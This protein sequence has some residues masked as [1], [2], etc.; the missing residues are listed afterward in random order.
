MSKSTLSSLT[1]ES[2]YT[3]RQQVEKTING[4]GAYYLILNSN[5]V[6]YY[7]GL[8]L[9]LGWIL[10][11]W[12]K[13]TWWLVAQVAL[14]GLWAYL[15]RGYP[16]FLIRHQR[17]LLN[18]LGLA[19]QAYAHYATM[20]PDLPAPSY[21]DCLKSNS[22]PQY[23]LDYIDSLPRI[24]RDRRRS[25]RA[26]E[27]EE[28]KRQLALSLCRAVE[29]R[30]VQPR[31]TDGGLQPNPE[32]AL[33]DQVKAVDASAL[34]DDRRQQFEQWV[35]AYHAKQHDHRLKVRLYPLQRALEVVQS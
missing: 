20:E 34:D 12:V 17:N 15:V 7:T 29:T 3:L 13:E 4:T 8:C 5:G 25:R 27:R 28:H 26:K 18:A 35:T 32:A 16:G 1:L 2:L 6:I 30:P 22:P 33:L 24:V 14:V 9:A 21:L 11:H 10:H 23:V 19:D 31:Q